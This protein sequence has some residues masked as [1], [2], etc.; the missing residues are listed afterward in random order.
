MKRSAM[1]SMSLA[2]SAAG[3]AW[4]ASVAS[5]GEGKAE[6]TFQESP[7]NAFG[8]KSLAD[9][10]GKPVLIDYWGTHCPP[11]V[12]AAV[13][14][15][16]KLQEELGDDLQVIFVESQGAN[17]DVYEAFAWK[18]KW[19]GN[20]AMWTDERPVNVEGDTI[21]KF[22]L[23]GADGTVLLTGNPLEK[24]K[25]IKELI[26]EEIEKGKTAPPGTPKAL[27]KAWSTFL[28]GD[29]TSALAECEKLGTDEAKAAREEFVGRVNSRIARAQWL[30]DNGFL[31][32]AD[33]LVT[34]L[35][36]DTKGVPDLA[37]NVAELTQALASDAA[38][39]E[40]EAAKALASLHD[41]IAK[42][43]PFDEGNVKKAKAIAE[44]FKGTKSGERAQRFVELSKIKLE[45]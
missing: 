12:G 30:I 17:R 36:K 35:E 5:I 42:E 10:R 22:A 14:A 18:M 3:C 32:Q 16:V 2:L 39:T 21:P 29:V 31:V 38:K 44:K 11:C 33:A 26:A 24:D 7:V 1:R 41:K 4:L 34:Q 23:I 25:Q 43:K 6:Y 37:A 19:M 28:K 13:P 20:T 9:L 40:R 8:V 15:S 45:I 27:A